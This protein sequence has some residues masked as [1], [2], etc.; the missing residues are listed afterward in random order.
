MNTSLPPLPF[1]LRE[2][3]PH[4]LAQ[5][6]KIRRSQHLLSFHSELSILLTL[7]TYYLIYPRT[8]PEAC[9]IL[10][11]CGRYLGALL[12]AFTLALSCTLT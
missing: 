4:D 3:H 8:H 9:P 10:S 5:T 12:S 1:Q 6:L 2:H 7:D 11:V